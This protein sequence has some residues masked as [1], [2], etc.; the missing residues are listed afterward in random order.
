MLVLAYSVSICKWTKGRFVIWLSLRRG[1]ESS[2]NLGHWGLQ[3]GCA[4]ST[5]THSPWAS[6]IITH[7]L[8]SWHLDLP[9]PEC[10]S[11]SS[12]HKTFSHTPSRPQ[13]T[14]PDAT[15]A[16]LCCFLR[17]THF[18]FFV[19][20]T[21]NNFLFLFFNLH[22]FYDLIRSVFL[23]TFGNNAFSSSSSSFYTWPL[24]PPLNSSTENDCGKEVVHK[25][26]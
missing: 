12:H 14:H 4:M 8:P 21:I 6:G 25:T 17:I 24:S 23:H 15:L 13:R 18:L 7:H 19:H 20:I 2:M 5:N 10:H 11:I 9:P 16:S 26:P 1:F 3:Q 22:C